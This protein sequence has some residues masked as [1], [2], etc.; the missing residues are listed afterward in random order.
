M[1]RRNRRRQDSRDRWLVSYADF[2]TLL[3]AFFVV[4]YA[5]S[6][7]D[8]KKQVQVS[9][10][11]DSA[12]R[13]LGIFANSGAKRGQQRDQRHRQAGHSDEYRDGRRCAF[14]GQGEGRLER[15]TAGAGAEA[16]QPDRPAHRF[17]S[18]GQGRTGHQPARGRVLRLR[19]RGA[20]TGN[21]GDTATGGGY[22]GPQPV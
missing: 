9:E 6:K 15:D 5:A 12:F 10:A 20:S 14:P 17:D 1:I 2:I 4:L 18:D 22:I 8:Q 19:I 7:A 11:I 13:T 16:L 21:A 3:F